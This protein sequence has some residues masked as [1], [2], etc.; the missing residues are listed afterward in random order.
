M[1]FLFVHERA[2]GDTHHESRDAL[3]TEF[4]AAGEHVHALRPITL[5]ARKCLCLGV[6]VSAFNVGPEDKLNRPAVV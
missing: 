5:R 6:E 4:E 2:F 3:R 1:P